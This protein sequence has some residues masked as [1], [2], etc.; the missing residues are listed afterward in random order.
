MIS[1]AVRSCI[2]EIPE[3]QVGHRKAYREVHIWRMLRQ[4]CTDNQSR[5]VRMRDGQRS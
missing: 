3:G 1:G 4:G 5:V 2:L